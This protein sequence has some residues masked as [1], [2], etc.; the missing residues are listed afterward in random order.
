MRLPLRRISTSISPA[1]FVCGLGM[2]VIGSA[3]L[4][5]QVQVPLP[6][7]LGEADMNIKARKLGDASVLLDMVLTRVDKG[8]TL[9][10]GVALENVQLM[11]ANTQFQLQNFARA[12]EVAN[13]LL[14]RTTTGQVAADARLVLGLSLALQKKFAEAVPVFAALEESTVYRDKALM[15]RSMAAQQANQPEVAIDALNRL[16]AT[17]PR[18][19]DWADSALT[20][21]ALQL[22]QRNLDAARRGLELL[23]GN[24]STVDNL[25]GLNVLSLQLGDTLLAGND[26]AGALTAY[27][28]V[29]GRSD[30]LRMQ[31]KRTARMETQ[32]ARQKSLFH[33]SITD[34]DTVRRVEARI[35]ATKEA[36][37]EIAK[38][39]DYD[40]T[41]FY[42]LGHTFLIRGGAWEAAI[43]FERLIKE[44]PEATEREL[45]YSELVRA[46]ADSGRIDKVR[47]TLDDYMRVLPDSKLL[48]QALYVAAQTAFDRGRADLQL[49]FLG[50]G[51]DRYPEAELTE[52]MVLMQTNAH[53]AGGR[54]EEAR[55]S[56]E[57]YLQKY[58]TGRF[59]EDATYLHA[60]ATLV[61][62]RATA[63][64]K[65]INDYVAK[66]PEGR[67]VAD[68]RYRV[69]AAEYALSDYA[70]AE[71]QLDAWL[72]DY[73]VD[74]PQR[75]EALSTQG[76]VYAG[77]GRIDDA[78]ASYRAAMSA[79]L[80]DDQLGYVLDELTKH[81]QSKR[82]FNSAAIM[83]EDFARERPDHPFV[84][85]AAYWIGR[86]RAREGKTDTAISQMGEIARRYITDPNR[87]AVERL[88]TQMATLLAR[89][90]KPG[91]DGVRP[92]PPTPA[93]IASRVR[94]ELL[95]DGNS[96]QPTVRARVLFTEAEVASI[97]KD[98]LLRD[99]L[100]AEIG[101]QIAPEALSPGLLGRVGDL[102]REQGKLERARACYDQ[103]VLRYPRSMYADFGYV[104]LGEL[105]YLAGDYDS[106]LIHFTNAIDRAGARFK[107]LEATLG[108]AKTLLASGKLSGAQELFE[109]IASTRSWRGEATAQ[110]IYSLG[111]ILLRRGTSEDLAQAQAHFQRVY[112]SYKKFT[113]W[114]ARAYL[115]SGQ[116]FEKLGQAK[117][118]LATYREMLRDDRLSAYP[119]TARARERIAVLELQ[120]PSTPA[121]P[122]ATTPGGAS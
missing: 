74:H 30:L 102:L 17:A 117:E 82:D 79:S 76:D 115:S 28:T 22:Q 34:T 98:T 59:A 44:F 119:E 122:V 9:P 31:K 89:N 24:L 21:I 48:P 67:F 38:K 88:L 103:L 73:P 52:F 106:A 90:P 53:F 19:A 61:L 64:I 78:I 18:D 68:G 12:E 120:V 95:A 50:V 47:A 100:L 72:T 58:P 29:L 62:G 109:R 13:Q 26:P 92:P 55:T 84:I 3:G 97:R 15:Y 104:G 105:A 83:W 121:T 4:Q 16:L 32:L 87:D 2:A 111:E 41:L 43:V 99:K 81:Y 63:A 49:E 46:Y 94:R 114:V 42:R 7:I 65:E 39:T 45:A 8:E 107:L 91:A 37:D 5:A 112:I 20:L 101:D 77:E 57:H 86:L 70:A 11:A 54:Y 108:Q 69:A 80:S 60:M 93:A 36:L 116:T 25:A 85:N 96:N 71:K 23:R 113:P 1:R 40:A 66:Y 75:G 51:I 33:G 118:A 14:K 10:A 56:A 110:S 35:K 27:R 6:Q